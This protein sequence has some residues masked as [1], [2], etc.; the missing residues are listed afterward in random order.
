MFLEWSELL[1]ANDDDFIL[2]LINRSVNDCAT[3]KNLGSP[4]E[5]SLSSGDDD[6]Y[7]ETKTREKRDAAEYER[8]VTSESRNYGSKKNDEDDAEISMNDFADNC[9]ICNNLGSP[10][11]LSESSGDD[12]DY[13]ETKTRE[14]RDTVEYERKGTSESRI[15]G[16]KK[17][18]EDDAEKEGET[19][20]GEEKKGAANEG[21]DDKGKGDE[22]EENDEPNDCAICKDLGPIKLYTYESSGDDDYGVDNSREKRYIEER[23]EG[24][25]DK[26]DTDEGDADEGKDVKFEDYERQNDEVENSEGEN[27]GENDEVENSEDEDNEENDEVSDGED[28]FIFLF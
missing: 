8:K 13:G 2:I 11:E 9:A 27:D 16:K 28:Y 3:C 1:W 5:L 15:D 6:D 14:K 4:I 20:V 22:V 24:D 23:N 12:D 18:D 19:G 10:I 17:N 26:G 7:V 21:K 25:K